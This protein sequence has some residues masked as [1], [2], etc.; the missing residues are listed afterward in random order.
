MSEVSKANGRIAWIDTAKGLGIMLVMFGH[1]Y[2]DG[3]FVFWLDSFHMPLFFFLSGC[4]FN[5][6][7]SFKPFLIKRIKGLV[8]PYV[9]FA[10]VI[11]AYDYLSGVTH[12]RSVDLSGIAF[13]YLIQKRYTFLWF[14]PCLFLA[15]IGTWMISKFIRQKKSA[16]NWLIV[17]A[18]EFM[19][20]FAYRCLVERDL[21]WNADTAVLAMGFMSLG[22]WYQSC[23][24][25]IVDEKCMKLP[26]IFTSVSMHFSLAL[27]SFKAFGDTSIALNN[28][29]NPV[30][31]LI[32]AVLGIFSTVLVS[33]KMN[34]RLLTYIGANSIVWYGFHRTIIDATFIVYNKL[35]IVIEPGSLMSLILAVVSTVFAAFLLIPVNMIL[36]K[37]FPFLIGKRRRKK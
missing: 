24:D 16:Q 21:P 22:I 20:F 18:I 2:L 11:G 3:K 25:S 9:F 19:T 8:I 28:Y 15:E 32:V 6:N 30:L 13:S 27:V 31:F 5:R 37:Y 23:I 14:L 34:L 1:N 33:K 29:G 4:T 10:F 35:N 12:G 36:A 17:S 26:I 7:E